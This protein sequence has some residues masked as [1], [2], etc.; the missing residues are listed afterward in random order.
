MAMTCGVVVVDLVDCG[1]FATDGIIS[2]EPQI[3]NGHQ[4][5][6]GKILDLEFSLSYPLVGFSFYFGSGRIPSTLFL[7][8][9]ILFVMVRILCDLAKSS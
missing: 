4:H 2:K 7:T 3:F 5:F 6:L 8:P 9:W 1:R